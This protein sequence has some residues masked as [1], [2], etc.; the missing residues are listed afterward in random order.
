MARL[1][2]TLLGGF[3]ARIATGHPIFI[4]RRKAQ[5]LL[6]HMGLHPG[7]PSPRELLTALLWGDVPEDRAR[8]SLRQTL[9]D[10]RH[11]LPNGRPPLILVEGDHIALSERWVD[12]DVVAFKRWAAKGTRAALERAAALYTG[13]LLAGL[14]L[15]EPA[16]ADWLRAERDSLREAA[17]RVLRRLLSAQTSDRQFEAAIQTA[18][19]LVTI[20]PLHESAHRALMELYER[21]GRRAAALRQFHVC[22]DLLERELGISPEP[23]TRRLYETL[24]PSPATAA[25]TPPAREPYRVD[26]AIRHGL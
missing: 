21:Q 20:D 18:M 8:H 24:L 13:D 16:F 9:H 5:A 1:V 26:P 23:A 11:A 7:Q 10:L 22:A 4:P 14:S 2:L 6:A 25:P 3:K 15:R 17:V 12:V 19:R